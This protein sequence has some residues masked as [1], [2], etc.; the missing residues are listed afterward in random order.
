MA[1]KKPQ[2]LRIMVSSTVYGIEELLEQV[3]ALLSGFGYEVWMSHKGTVPISPNQT[4]LESCLVAAERC[5]LF[6]S[7]IT[8]QYGT[9]MVKGQLSITHQELLRAIELDKPRWI[10]AHDHVV[11]ARS[12]L[13]KLG[14]KS[15]QE[16]D[17]LLR[18]LGFDDDDKLKKLRN[19]EQL[20]FD[21]FRVIDMYEAAIRHD[22]KVYQDR[23]GN[24]VQKFGEPDD[25]KLFSTAQ[26]SRYRDV[27]KFLDEQFANEQ[28]V[29]TRANGGASA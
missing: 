12:L 27:Q 25:V 5:D 8:P 26:F 14:A 29:Q 17:K 11:F 18:T 6:L 1:K 28:E 16:R 23:K 20:V 21:D 19:E 15:Q 13:R 4:A 24:W 2:S 9:G 10:L 7:I 3:Y 22:L